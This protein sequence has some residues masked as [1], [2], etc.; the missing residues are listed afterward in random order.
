MNFGMLVVLAVLAF[1]FCIVLTPSC[2]DLFLR[3]GLVDEPDTDRKLHAVPVPRCGGIGVVLSYFA[4]L[5]AA[6]LLLPRGYSL[7]V[8]HR[9][10]FT[11]LL[12]ATLL[13]FLVGLADDL[14]NLRARQKFMGQTVA[15]VLAV[16]LGARLTLHH[17]PVWIGW[18]LS[19]IWLL[20]C[21]NAVNLIDGMDGLATGVGLT[22]TFTT[23]SVAL[24]TGNTGLA[25]ATAPLAG[26][27]L[28]F[29]RFN[30]APASVFLGDSGSLTIG[31]LL[32]CL[33]LVWSGHLGGWGMLGPLFTLGLPLVDV[34]LAIGRRLLREAPI[35]QGDHG[36]I[37]HRVQDLGLSTRHA[38]LLLYGCCALFACLAVVQSQLPH[39]PAL[40]F[41]VL[42]V[43]MV[44]AGVHQLKYVEFRVAQRMLSHTLIRR[45]VR[46]QIHLEDMHRG[47]MRAANAEDCWKL[48]RRACDQLD[49]ASV[50]LKLGERRFATHRFR[51][52][53][54]P[55]C[56]M[57]VRLG[58]ECWIVLIGSI[59]IAPEALTRALAPLRRYDTQ[60]LQLD[61]EP[62][63]YRDAA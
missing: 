51:V 20:A 36:H 43:A 21:T 11:A 2:R 35:T 42:F 44:G 56:T 54:D 15:A 7:Y 40:V 16:S 62:V 30:F 57:H 5:G 8:Q 52:L 14:L 1:V 24:L 48:V 53:N 47:L 31:F 12:P 38:A 3:K 25:I 9:P 49:I 28:A 22:A 39:W 18:V 33:G 46:Q 17:G 58:E 50:Q 61:A 23:L 60:R 63:A 45:A 26:A 41:L 4:A 10:L 34:T 6:Y 37:H 29:L 32:G 59:N 27:L 55:G 13:I 19:V